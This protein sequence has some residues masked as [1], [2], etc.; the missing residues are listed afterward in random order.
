MGWFYSRLY[1]VLQA[2]SAVVLAGYFIGGLIFGLAC[3]AIVKS[4]GYPE[5]SCNRNTIGG[6]FLWWIWLIVCTC[7][8]RG[9][10]IRYSGADVVTLSGTS[11]A[12]FWVLLLSGGAILLIG[13]A[14]LFKTWWGLTVAI[15]GLAWWIVMYVTTG[16]KQPKAPAQKEIN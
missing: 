16:G 4:K 2:H 15:A 11:D 6:F 10:P 5:D 14:L 13:C 12:R 8:H 3:R 1:T 7:K 9:R